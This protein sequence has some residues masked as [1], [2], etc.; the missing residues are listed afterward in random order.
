MSDTDDIQLI[1]RRKRRASIKVIKF[2]TD[3]VYYDNQKQDDC[4]NDDNQQ[5]SDNIHDVKA[6]L[7]DI[8]DI[9]ST[10]K[11][12]E[13]GG[14]RCRNKKNVKD[15]NINLISAD[16]SILSNE[17]I[18]DSKDIHESLIENNFS[19]KESDI[20]ET[21]FLKI[22]QDKIIEHTIQLYSY[23]LDI[24]NKTNDIQSSFIPII[25]SFIVVIGYIIDIKNRNQIDNNNTNFNINY[26]V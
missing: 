25:V 23:I 14:K 16:F 20:D 3:Y 24:N 2:K 18:I 4:I 8:T 19:N 10:H 15:T 1:K 6:N 5:Y 13:I 12:I 9:N 11:Q 17:L 26:I 7:D 21:H 22:N